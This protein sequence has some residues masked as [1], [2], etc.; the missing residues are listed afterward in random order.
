MPDRNSFL[1]T[2]TDPP[3]QA[4]QKIV[5]REKDAEMVRRIQAIIMTI[6]LGDIGQVLNILDISKDTLARWIKRYNEGGLEGLAKK[7]DLGALRFWRPP[8]KRA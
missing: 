4:L 5:K 3:V 2:R 7:N 1:I 8:S 6:I